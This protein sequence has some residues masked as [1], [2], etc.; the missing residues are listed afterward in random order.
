MSSSANCWEVK[1]CGRQPGGPKAGEFGVCPAATASGSYP[2]RIK[3]LV[4]AVYSPILK[5]CPVHVSAPSPSPI[6][7]G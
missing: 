1:Q 5:P 7:K 3:A 2:R 6:R 4:F